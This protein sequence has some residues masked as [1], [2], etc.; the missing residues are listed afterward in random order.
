MFRLDFFGGIRHPT[1][2]KLFLRQALIKF[3]WNQSVKIASI[4]TYFQISYYEKFA[5]CWGSTFDQV[6]FLL[7]C[8]FSAVILV[9][10][11]TIINFVVNY[12]YPHLIQ[13]T[14]K[15]LLLE[16][17]WASFILGHYCPKGTLKAVACPVGT[18]NP[19]IGI[20][21]KSECLNCTSGMYCGSQGLEEPS[22]NC[23]AGYF[24][25]SGASTKKP[26]DASGTGKWSLCSRVV[27]RLLIKR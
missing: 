13:S 4:G 3:F 5:K 22:G 25:S 12:P 16:I 19:S 21:A 26:T 6:C 24:C 10:N 7:S 18:Y 2:E 15:Q 8:C 27:L 17:I 14:F 9:Q 1:A 20:S 11:V 23:S